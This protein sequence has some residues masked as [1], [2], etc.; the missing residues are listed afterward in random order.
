V[1]V[2]FVRHGETEFNK[3]RICQGHKDSPLTLRG[4]RSAEKHG[5]RLS[6]ERIGI[7]YSSDLGRCVETARIINKFLRVGVVRVSELRERDFGY[8]NG[9]SYDEIKRKLNLSNPSEVA[10][11]GESF[12]QMKNRVLLFLKKVGSECFEK[13]V[14]V[15][16]KGPLRAILS[17]F[18][19]TNFVSGECDSS[20]ENIYLL[21]VRDGKIMDVKVIE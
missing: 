14:V 11:G 15:S 21:E 8:F 4:V 10:P 18:Y 19:K 7:I 2:Y 12:N 5:K 1:F 9:R 6:K 17:E 3:K 13:V 20:S 16:H